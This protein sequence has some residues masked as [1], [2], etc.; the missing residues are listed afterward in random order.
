[1]RARRESLID[2]TPG[3]L[4]VVLIACCESGEA[5]R[6]PP[7]VTGEWGCDCGPK[8]ECTSPLNVCLSGL[9][10]QLADLNQGG[11]GTLGA[12][13]CRGDDGAEY[14]HAQQHQFPDPAG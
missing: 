7:C 4:L 9:C 8:G 2:R 6:V 11:A 12:A 10:V 1:M 13:G 3:L 5:S 14:P